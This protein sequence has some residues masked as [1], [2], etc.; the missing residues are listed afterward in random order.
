MQALA[1][2]RIFTG[3]RFLEQ[4]AVL[5]DGDTIAGV[6]PTAELPADL[7]RVAL[8]GGILAPGFVDAQVNG[9]GGV[10]FNAT[11]DAASLAKLAAAHARHGSTALLP[12]FITDRPERM[13]LA[14]AAASE[15]IAAGTPGIVG[16]HLEGP[17]LAASRKGAHD[18]ALI[19]KL[20]DADV[21]LLL[22]TGI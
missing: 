7:E 2:A 4:H 22:D 15:A 20:T 3:D 8:A 12:T 19:R 16:L 13:A 21:D 5:L 14:I 17:F 10:L 9:G 11:P 1:G 18:P 6:A